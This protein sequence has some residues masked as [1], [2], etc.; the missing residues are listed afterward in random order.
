[1]NDNPFFS[2]SAL[3][4]QLPPFAAIREEH[5]APALE[6]GMALQL[7]EIAAITGAASAASA[8]SATAT[9][10]AAVTA[11]ATAA[12]TGSDTSSLPAAPTFE[13]TII[14]LE[15]SGA[16]SRRALAAFHNK[17]DSD[18]TPGLQAL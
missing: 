11:A 16:V 10:A 4:Y 5:Y 7:E 6:R 12:G 1:M 3:P 14:A 13:N 8:A 2:P 9:S 15:R 18:T 17:A